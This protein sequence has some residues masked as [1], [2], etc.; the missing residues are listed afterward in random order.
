VCLL[1]LRLLKILPLS[2]LSA[3]T[4]PRTRT[5]SGDSTTRAAEKVRLCAFIVLNPASALTAPQGWFSLGATGEDAT[6]CLILQSGSHACCRFIVLF[7]S[8]VC[9]ALTS[10]TLFCPISL[11]QLVP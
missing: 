7:G 2:E 9:R 11:P 3:T 6:Q 4:S 1:V 8:R 5:S 10:A